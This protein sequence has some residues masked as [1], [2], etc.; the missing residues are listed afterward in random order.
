[1]GGDHGGAVDHGVAQ[2]LRL[3]A[4]RR[5]DPQGFQTEG[6]IGGGQPLQLAVDGAG[7][8]GQV[9]ARLDLG[10]AHGY[11][12]QTQTIVVRR[13]VEIVA[14]VH[15]RDQETQFLGKL[16]AHALD[17]RHQLA[18]LAF[19]DHG[20]QAV[21]DLETDQIH[22]FDVFPGQ[23][24]LLRL[25]LDFGMY[26]LGLLRLFLLLD[27][28]PGQVTGDGRQRQEGEIGH[29]RNQAEQGHDDGGDDQRARI[30]EHLRE[31]LLAHLLG[32][33]NPGD[34]DGGGGGQHQGRDLRHQAVTDGQQGVV[35]HRAGEIHAV[36][37]HADGEATND[38][39]EQ[40]HDA[41]DGIA[42]HEL[43]G[44]VHGAVEVGFLGHLG[45]PRPRLLLGDQTG[46]EIGVDGHLL[47]RHRIQGKA[48]ADFGHATRTLGDDDEVDDDQNAEHHQADSVV[49][50]DDEFAE[51]LDHLARGR[52]S[53]VTFEQHHPG[54][55][56]VQRQPQQGGH[57]QDGREHRE[58]QRAQ[59]IDRHQQHDQREGDVEGEQHVQ[60]H[61]RQ[62][63]HHHRQHHDDQDRR[64]ESL[65]AETLQLLH[66]RIHSSSAPGWRKGSM[67]PSGRGGS[68]PPYWRTRCIW[69]T[70]ASTWA[71]A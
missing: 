37:H 39:D 54:G 29:A 26:R 46:I 14:D 34:D 32:V 59:G 45:A 58:I 64:A 8:D 33:G 69:N 61:R 63:N 5:I 51:G 17:A 4:Q 25:G 24:L 15:R 42:A 48:R 71:T 60:R 36:L 31:H 68:S 7:V 30:L 27:D 67:K 55:G 13:Q 66:D 41:G 21:A 38:I 20:N 70:K 16:L 57:Q 53:G 52:G 44:A 22:R 18:A 10:F 56:D 28:A 11:A 43:A 2:G 1:M 62:R 3:V 23:F 50:A 35:L 65:G 47:A 6:G 12:E 19:V 49:A 9:L 40:N